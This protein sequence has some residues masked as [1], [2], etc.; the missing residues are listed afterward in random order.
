MLAPIYCQ[1]EVSVSPAAEEGQRSLVASA[2]GPRSCDAAPGA[3]GPYNV[4]RSGG[5][6]QPRLAAALAPRSR[7]TRPRETMRTAA[8]LALTASTLSTSAYAQTEVGSKTRKKT[9]NTYAKSRT[10]T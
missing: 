10:R 2:G 4:V 1:G 7:K 9:R 5:M 6:P 8:V 3:G